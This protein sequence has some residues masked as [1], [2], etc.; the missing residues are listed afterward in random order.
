MAKSSAFGRIGSGTKF[1][2]EY[3]R[4]VFESS[5]KIRNN[6]RHVRREGTEALLNTLLVADVCVDIFKNYRVL[7]GRVPEYGVLPVPSG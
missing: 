7:N 5:L 4:I 2:E 6:I 1:V 3:Q